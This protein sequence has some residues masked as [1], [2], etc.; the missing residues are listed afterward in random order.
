MSRFESTITELEEGGKDITHR[1]L[2]PHLW[3][4]D[5]DKLFN[6]KTR[7]FSIYEDEH[8]LINYFRL[9]R[10]HRRL[11]LTYQEDVLRAFGGV[12]TTYERHMSSKFHFGMP[13]S[14]FT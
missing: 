6:L 11:T 8:T 3:V 12:I 1:F 13:L 2:Y 10:N 9:F 14:M 5:R 7:L 4:D